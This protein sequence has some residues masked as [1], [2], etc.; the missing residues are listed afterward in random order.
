[1]CLRNFETRIAWCNCDVIVDSV[2]IVYIR[3]Q[4]GEPVGHFQE[5]DEDNDE[6]LEIGRKSS[7]N[8]IFL[9]LAT[10]FLTEAPALEHLFLNSFWLNCEAPVCSCNQPS[11]IASDFGS[12]DHWPEIWYLP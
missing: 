5:A 3:V 6:F 8:D 10:N 7:A 4:T 9:T 11:C 1:M 12:W 2:D